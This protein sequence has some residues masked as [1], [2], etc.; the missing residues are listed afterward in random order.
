MSTWYVA[1]GGN[2]DWSGTAATYD[3]QRNGPKATLTAALEAGRKAAAGKPRRIVLAPGRY[4]FKNKQVVDVR[5]ND[6]T[7]TGAGMGKTILYG[8]VRLT[9]WR[10]DGERFW[11]AGA[12]GVKEGTWDFRALVVNDH[13]CPR[14]RLPEKGRFRHLS[15]FPVRWMSSAG[16]GWERK[17]TRQELTTLR[18]REGDLGPWLNVRNAE[19]TVYH[20]WDESMV[21]LAT[22]D[23]TNRTLTFSSPCTHPPGAFGV[24]T[25]VVWNVRE[26]MKHPGQWY[27]DRD[28]GVVVYW[29]LPGEDMRKARAVAPKVETVIRVE[30]SRKNAVRDVTIRDMTVSATTTPCKSGGFGAFRFHGALDLF[31]SNNVRIEHVEVRNV[32]GYGIREWGSRKVRIEECRIHHL[33]AGGCRVGGGSG[34]VS[35]NRIHHVGLIYPSAVGLSAGGRDSTY[36]VRRNVIHDTSYSG[37]TVS[38][39]AP[40]I[41]ENVLYRCMLELHD[42]AAI[43]LGGA[44]NAVVR[45]NVT[46]DIVSQGKGYGVSAYYLDEKCLDCVV[47][48]NLSIGIARPSHNHMTRNCSLRN[49]TF[50]ADGDMVL[51]F[52]R[53]AG[54]QVTGN[55]FQLKGELKVTDPDA[56][57]QWK[58]NLIVRDG[59]AG[60][61]LSAALPRPP[62]P[63]DKNPRRVNVA[64]A[65]RPPV[66]DGR[67]G[68]GEWPPGGAG[69]RERPDRRLGRGA[70]VLAKFCADSANLYIAVNVVFMFPEKRRIG[71]VWGRDEGVEIALQGRRRDGTAVVYVL[72]GFADGQWRSV[73]DGGASPAEAAALK[74]GAAYAATVDKKVWRCEWRLPLA[75]LRFTPGKGVFLPANVTVW[76]A[77]DGEYLQLAG[78]LGK[79]WDPTRGG[80][81]VFPTAGTGVGASQVFPTVRAA[82]M[83][84]APVI[85]GRA[86]NGEWPKTALL[87][88]QS[89]S[90]I[91]IE[92]EP[93]RA[94]VAA[95][96]DNLYVHVAVPV[97]GSASV[98]KGAEWTRDDGAEVCIRGRSPDGKPVVWVVHGFAGGQYESSAEA[99]ASA[100][101]AKR[102]ERAV[103]FKSSIGK[104]DWHGEWRLP[105]K[106]LG[107]APSETGEIPFNLGVYHRSRKQWIIWVGTRGPSWKV[108][109]AGR[110]RLPSP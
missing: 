14:A 7:I 108:S 97:E 57:A 23:T 31:W 3:G 53:S 73:T 18:Y 104:N 88:R 67:I 91:P 47:E 33:G 1:P 17:P 24:D 74:K 20:M 64:H 72:R 95:D 60:P 49:N 82:R 32:A 13:L 28:R 12:P 103:A 99:G 16:G 109:A 56:I 54:F 61:A 58:D 55:I 71:H 98:S 36:V 51:S 59:E 107:I 90:G 5:D 42:G 65:T 92:G 89:P 105:L 86:S 38:G 43:Y 46:R 69:I 2:D 4:Y 79:T 96:K 41:E 40:V 27:L 6:L 48:N 84:Q 29:P 85:D 94:Y 26:G 110:L 25:Y 45:R 100:A 35:G 81:L 52:Q 75:V 68:G 8:G 15:R 106:A 87:L 101:D 83:P 80:R 34:I 70:P 19:V 62:Q 77:E 44:K 63:A 9:G 37:M 76:R 22:I 11:A 66:I 30:G 39:N 102:L 93:C 50:V 10:P 21:G 78:A